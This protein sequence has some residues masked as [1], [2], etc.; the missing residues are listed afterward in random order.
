[1]AVSSEKMPL[2][3]QNQVNALNAQREQ[4]ASLQYAPIF[5]QVYLTVNCHYSR[6]TGLPPE[7]HLALNV[8]GG[9]HSTGKIMTGH[10][11]ARQV[12]ALLI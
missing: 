8:Q 7:K 6:E 3:R 5:P 11:A 12:I 10:N 2:L 4:Y 1:M 9:F